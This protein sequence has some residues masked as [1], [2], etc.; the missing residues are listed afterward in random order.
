M[1]SEI[2]R[3]QRPGRAEVP[4]LWGRADIVEYCNRMG[5]LTATGKQSASRRL[6]CTRLIR[7][8]LLRFRTL[9]LAS[10]SGVLEGM[11]VDFATWPEDMPDEPE[12]AEVG[13][14]LTEAVMH[15]LCSHLDRL[16]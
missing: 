11:P 9:G 13:R 12:D 15:I 16:E 8:V 14:D 4:A 1:L 7:R 5:H 3:L 10:P 6:A 2:L